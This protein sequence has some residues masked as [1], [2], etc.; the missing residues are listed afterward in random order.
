M[1]LNVIVSVTSATF[2][3]CKTVIQPQSLP[4]VHHISRHR[5]RFTKKKNLRLVS[6]ENVFNSWN[7][8]IFLKPQT[9]QL[10]IFI[11]FG[12]AGHQPPPIILP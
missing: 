7:V 6:L 8:R 3:H 5:F 4:R 2:T 9:F 12:G 1:N 10:M 11:A